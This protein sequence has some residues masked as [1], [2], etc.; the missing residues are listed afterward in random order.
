MVEGEIRQKLSKSSLTDRLAID[1][2]VT[3]YNSQMQA[4][5]NKTSSNV[6]SDEKIKTSRSI[7]IGT[8]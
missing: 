5:I 2:L 8:Y 4:K 6:D 7:I 1:L 3:F